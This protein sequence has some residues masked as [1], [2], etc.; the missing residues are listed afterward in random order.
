MAKY[1]E[2]NVVAI[3][4]DIAEK[5]KELYSIVNTIDECKK[6]L[7]LLNKQKVH[8]QFENSQENNSIVELIQKAHKKIQEDKLSLMKEKIRL[9]FLAKNQVK[10]A[11]RVELLL[12]VISN[13]QD[14]QISTD[15]TWIDSL[16]EET[17]KE[18]QNLVLNVE[19]E[20]K[21]KENIVKEKN[22]ILSDL[23]FKE[24]ELTENVNFLSEEVNQKNELLSKLKTENN[25]LSEKIERIEKVEKTSKVMLRRLSNEWLKHYKGLP[26]DKKLL[27]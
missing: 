22:Q 10:L 19:I 18:L 23:T 4:R 7:Y 1:S 12:T 15:N 13:L 5:Q 26:F 14:K 25:A 24:K 16:K 9:E 21:A 27:D 6:D 2:K 11:N 17:R 3:K 20:R 8:F